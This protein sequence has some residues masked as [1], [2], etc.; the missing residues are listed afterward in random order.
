[1]TTWLKTRKRLRRALES[2][3]HRAMIKIE[4]GV[5]GLS[6]EAL[7]FHGITKHGAHPLPVFFSSMA[8]E[9][10]GDRYSCGGVHQVSSD[11]D[12]LNSA[13][14]SE[15]NGAGLDGGSRVNAIKNTV[16]RES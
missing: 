7:V 12:A 2:G 9:E 3:T 16:L 10:S 5:I 15:T 4:P 11:L 6:S 13:P 8:P 1:M 14:L